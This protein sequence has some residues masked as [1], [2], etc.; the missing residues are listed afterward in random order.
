VRSAEHS[1]HPQER[2]AGTDG[3]K[4]TGAVGAIA[5]LSDNSTALLSVLGGCGAHTVS[6]M[7]C[8]TR[9]R[10]SL[11]EQSRYHDRCLTLNSRVRT[12]LLLVL[13]PHPRPSR[14]S[15]SSMKSAR[16]ATRRSQ[17]LRLA[18]RRPS[19]TT[20]P[21]TVVEQCETSRRETNTRHQPTPRFCSTVCVW[22]KR[23]NH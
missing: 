13:S 4:R 18:S 14:S 15:S 9:S 3:R 10:T 7:R 2:E 21:L 20:D 19:H 8:Q 23:L 17:R 6:V 5:C 12:W 1:V 11:T 16:Y 22:W